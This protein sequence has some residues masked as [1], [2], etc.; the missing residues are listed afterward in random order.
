MLESESNI[1]FLTVVV[2]TLWFIVVVLTD[3]KCSSSSGYVHIN[4][5]RQRVKFF[6]TK[7]K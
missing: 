6:C 4:Y 2:E 1:I 7:I 3:L 5:Y